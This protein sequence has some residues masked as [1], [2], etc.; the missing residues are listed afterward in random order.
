[1][2]ATSKKYTP[3]SWAH[4]GTGAIIENQGEFHQPEQSYGKMTDCPGLPRTQEVLS[5]DKCHF[6]NRD[7]PE[8]MGKTDLLREKLPSSG[9]WLQS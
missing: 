5:T 3:R 9:D 4:S 1:M 8:K 2:K 7:N 6:Q